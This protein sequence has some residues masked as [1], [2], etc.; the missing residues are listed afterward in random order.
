[1]AGALLA[2]QNWWLLI[3]W[4]AYVTPIQLVRMARENGVLEAEFGEAFRQLR[5]HTWF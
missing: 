3:L 5:R 1:M 2:L 4:L